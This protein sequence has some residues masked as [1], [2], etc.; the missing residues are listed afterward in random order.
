MTLEQPQV[1]IHLTRKLWKEFISDQPDSQEVERLAGI[2]RR[3]DYRIK[4]L[5]QA[6]LSSPQFWA[7]ENRAALIKSPVELLIGTIRLFHLPLPEQMALARA[8]R[9]L[10]QDLFDPSNVKGWPGGTRWIT[11]A[12]LPARWH[13]LQQI[14][15]GHEVGH[16]HAEAMGMGDGSGMAGTADWLVTE[17]AGGLQATLLAVPPVNPMPPALTASPG[18]SVEDR[19]QFVRQLVLDPAYQLK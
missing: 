2:F 9:R 6:L 13:I 8:G 18:P 12:T 5:L 4:P 10:G 11:T 7:N 15:R 14:I 19:R 16:R 17:P 3:N 1:A